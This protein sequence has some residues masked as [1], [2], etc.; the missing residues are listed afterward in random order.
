MN[1][2]NDDLRWNDLASRA[3]G[4]KNYCVAILGSIS[5]LNGT[6]DIYVRGT[7]IG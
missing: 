7:N 2:L 3:L 1:S 4:N 6:A 5:N